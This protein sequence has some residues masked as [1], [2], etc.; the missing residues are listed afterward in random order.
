MGTGGFTQ[1]MAGELPTSRN[2]TTSAGG[3]PW[4]CQNVWNVCE[5]ES[6]GVRL[7]GAYRASSTAGNRIAVSAREVTSAIPR[8]C[9]PA[10]LRLTEKL[11][12]PQRI[13]ELVEETFARTS[14]FGLLLNFGNL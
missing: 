7:N 2:M 1:K 6:G 11:K 9:S 3:E 8:F 10:G 12:M 13:V 4:A 14:G 5:R